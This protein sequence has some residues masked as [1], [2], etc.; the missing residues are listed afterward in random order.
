MATRTITVLGRAINAL[1]GA[2]TVYVNGNLVHQG[3]IYT[4]STNGILF[5]FNVTVPDIGQ[6]EMLTINDS[7][8]RAIT[9]VTQ[10]FSITP[11]AGDLIVD[12][13][14]SPALTA[15][16]SPLVIDPANFSWP[17]NVPPDPIEPTVFDPKYNGAIDNVAITV[18]REPGD[19]GS[20]PFT[21]TCNSVLTFDV[22][23]CAYF[24]YS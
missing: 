6:A 18:N 3:D 1:Q 11:T 10:Q 13:V 21:V 16:D 15:G 23:A 9:L 4:G 8:A 12:I 2:A 5:A 20:Y 19:M 17:D 24:T 14:Q 7:N 22:D